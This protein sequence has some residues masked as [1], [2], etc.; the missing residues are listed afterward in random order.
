[1]TTTAERNVPGFAPGSPGAEPAPPSGR[2]VNRL[3]L[4]TARRGGIWTPLL[5]AAAV[6]DAAASIML[7]AVLAS[8]VDAVLGGPQTAGP[9]LL[10]V[11]L[12]VLSA[13]GEVATDFATGASTARATAW[14]RRALLRRIMAIGPGLRLSPGDLTG[15]VVSTAAETGTTPATFVTV[16]VSMLPPAGAIIALVIIDWRIAVTLGVAM[17]LIAL[18]LR[19][20]V[21][22]TADTVQ[23]YF[24]VQGRIAAR[25][26][27]ALRGHRTIAAAHTGDQEVERIL[28]QLPQLRASGET[29][30]RT[31]GVI[32]ARATL[33]EL[34]LRVAVLTVA[35]LELSSDRISP[36]QFLAAVQYAAMATGL[37]GLVGTVVRIGRARASVARAAEVLAHPAPRYGTDELPPGNGQLRFQGV[38][39]DVL[40]EIDLTVPG[41]RAT[42][43]VGCSGAG[44]SRLAAL[45]GRLA[46]PEQG[47]VLLDGVP[48]TRLAED[49]LRGAVAY[50]F[51]R[52]VL[53]GETMA[54]AIAFG[55]QE[56]AGEQI[57]AAAR[58]ACAD[59]F[60]RRLP[61]GYGTPLRDTPMSG[62]ELQ[63]VGLARAFANTGRLLILDDAT[64]SLDTATEL[65]ITEA[66]LDRFSDR[67][68]LI[69][70]HRA[71]TAARADQVIWLENGR[72]RACDAH[73]V[74]WR[75][76]DYRA[77]FGV[78]ER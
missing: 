38:D 22:D 35:G 47:E 49:E 18:L 28:A 36:G 56:R 26:A 33:T 45:S 19:S 58:A 1:M 41:G 10:F 63:R 13:A 17:P 11:A 50:A 64:S 76:P 6:A 31:Q 67:T 68:R 52:P 25:L 7:P 20:F 37:A 55:R 4:G 12:V 9:V 61:D 74:L 39:A 2:E 3:L 42:A 43:V 8:A 16:V 15:R 5:A 24:A 71:A 62:G 54:D 21:N 59:G 72:V 57:R 48:L 73:D 60:I 77:V 23:H 65:Q 69:I 44:K 70:A 75:D 46:D 34:M 40:R 51:A 53:F 27:G 14:M 32:S 78:D 30:L 29:M 66:I